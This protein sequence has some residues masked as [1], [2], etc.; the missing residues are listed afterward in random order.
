MQ[1]ALFHGSFRAYSGAGI[2]ARG[3]CL[4]RTDFSS[5]N[6]K[7]KEIATVVGIERPQTYANGIAAHAQVA[8][9]RDWTRKPPG[10]AVQVCKIER[11]RTGGALIRRFFFC[12]QRFWRFKCDQRSQKPFHFKGWL[13][14]THSGGTIYFLSPR[15]EVKSFGD[16]D[17]GPVRPR[18]ASFREFRKSFF[19]QSRL[20]GKTSRN[21][22]WGGVG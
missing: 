8:T 17:S 21:S 12:S 22:G 5:L 13:P 4:V 19:W 15:G 3:M 6:S 16:F 2:L 11:A 20:F 7:P 9:S 1:P 10:G 18:H 14:P